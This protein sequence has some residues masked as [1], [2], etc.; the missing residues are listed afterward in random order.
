MFSEYRDLDRLEIESESNYLRSIDPQKVYENRGSLGLEERFIDGSGIIDNIGVISIISVCSLF[1]SP[2]LS[3]FIIYDYMSLA[4]FIVFLSS[5]LFLYVIF[6]LCP[7]QERTIHGTYYIIGNESIVVIP[8]N[9]R[10]EEDVISLDE[11]SE[12][13]Y[14]NGKVVFSTDDDSVMFPI[15]EE[16]FLEIHSLFQKI[17]E[18]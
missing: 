6:R 10:F 5:L 13:T 3:S 8:K 2:F 12:L 14:K 9:Q 1:I 4:L 16:D 15:S 11:L 18:D 17:G 7:L